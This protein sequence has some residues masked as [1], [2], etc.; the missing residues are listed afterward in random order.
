[1]NN[2][3][4]YIGEY[5]E[6]CRYRK[7]LDPKTLKAYR[8][9]LGQYESFCSSSYEFFSKNTVDHFITN[10]HKQYRRGDAA[11][12]NGATVSVIEGQTQNCEFKSF[13]SLS[14]I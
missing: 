3:N 2:L 6:F 5:L 7:R 10:L 12:E 8:I 1:M 9:D 14:G 4:N 13:F 11:L